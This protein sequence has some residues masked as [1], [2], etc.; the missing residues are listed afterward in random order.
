[1]SISRT[2]D[3]AAARR[4]A[5]A[6]FALA[7]EASKQ[8][9]IVEELS[10]LAEAVAENAELRQVL[11]NP[12]VG[13]AEKAAV[14]SALAAKGTDLTKRAVE[15]IAKGGRATLLPVIAELLRAELA[16][17]K[18]ELVA[19]VTSARPL[20]AAMQKQ[21]ADALTKATGKKVQMQLKEDPSVLGGVAIQMGSL[22]LDATLSGALN[23]LRGQLLAA[24]NA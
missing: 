1:M 10:V 11:A 7:T 23:N 20:A 17:Q 3:I 2:E 16:A 14:L 13:R 19:E 9:K 21:I 15:T 24:S 12:L 8:E 22:K 18:G 4:Y 5:T 6:V